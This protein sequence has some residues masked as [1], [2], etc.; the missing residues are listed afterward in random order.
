MELL[1]NILDLLKKDSV[2]EIEYN[3]TDKLFYVSKGK[4]NFI[5]IFISDW[6]KEIKELLKKVED[7]NQEEETN[8]LIEGTIRLT[9][10]NFARCHIVLPP[11]SPVPLITIARKSVS[12]TNLDGLKSSGSMNIDMLNF[13]KAA[14]ATNLTIVIS[15]G[16][17]SGKTTMLEA[18]TK[19]WGNHLR[20][21]VVEDARELL[22]NQ[23]NVFYLK[24]DVN[25]PGKDMNISTAN[26]AW[27]VK[28]LQR[29]RCDKIIIGETRGE[30]FADFIVAAGSGAE[31]SLTTLHANNSRQCLQ[32]MNGFINRAYQAPQSVINRSIADV[33][34]V[35]VQIIRYPEGKYRVKEITLV[36][37]TLSN[38]SAATITTSPIFEYDEIND[39]WKS[40]SALPDHI[41]NHFRKYGYDTKKFTKIANP[42]NTTDSISTQKIGLNETN[43]E[44]IVN[45]KPSFLGGIF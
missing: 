23:D 35:I 31:G 12:L 5:P 3:G 15:G 38:D 1:N 2:S 33:V 42:F 10:T 9:E 11:I 45:K 16:T 34:D 29:M 36:T 19:E 32:K 39:T 6:R 26:L 14:I 30:E 43:P 18:M 28:Q 13:L 25:T 37:R 27:C 21:G 44:P 40:N 8:Y 24:S 20:I 17:G 4:R 22:L 41:T 7:S